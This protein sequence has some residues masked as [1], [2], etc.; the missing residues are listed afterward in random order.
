MNAPKEVAEEDA[1]Q[2]GYHH[3]K[4]VRGLPHLPFVRDYLL[5]DPGQLW[6]K[7]DY[8]Q[9]EFRILAHY[10][11]GALLKLFK[12]NPNMDV[13]VLVASLIFAK[14]MSDV[15]KD[16]RGIAKTIGFG[17]LYG[18]GV[19]KLAAKLKRSED[20]ARDL[21]GQY[22]RALPG[23]K[24]LQDGIKSLVRADQPICTWGG[25]EYYC[26]PPKEERGWMRTFEYK[27]LNYLI[28][29]SAADCTKQAIINYHEHPKRK[30]RFLLTVHD[31]INASMPPKRLA[32]E[33][34][35]LE[36]SMLDVDFGVPM[37]SD[38]KAGPCWGQLSKA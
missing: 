14:P 30:A 24:G 1:D 29:G 11:D 9:Q 23:I 36:E 5:P 8:S 7:R 32:E 38:G 37:L 6:G 25:R 26:E 22:M 2:S 35:V 28:Q 4:H 13:H 33:M 10:E 31:E 3:P 20:E 18:L 27:L 17:L 15:T 12:A 21:K 19:P 34:K 16:E